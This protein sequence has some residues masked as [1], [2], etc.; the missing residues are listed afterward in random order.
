MKGTINQQTIVG[1]VGKVK[2]L[3]NVAELSVATNDSDKHV[4]WHSVKVFGQALI[5]LVKEH[6]KK[7]Q[8]IYVA[9]RTVTETWNTRDGEPK[10]AKRVFA[11]SIEILNWN[12]PSDKKKG[13]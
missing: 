4:E 11:S 2:C 3:E 8:L 7:G 10:S 1:H 12:S 13:D 6:V 9:G 5:T